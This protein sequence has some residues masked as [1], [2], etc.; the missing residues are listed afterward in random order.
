MPSDSQPPRRIHAGDR[1]AVALLYREYFPV[2]WRYVYAK[3]R[4]D[5]QATEDVV[6]ETFLGAVEWARNGTGDIE[7]PARWLTAVAKRQVAYYLRKK[8]RGN[9]RHA[10]DVPDC[11]VDPAVEASDEET[12]W[13]L[14][15]VLDS[16]PEEERLA[17]EW[18]YLDGWSA[19]DIAQ[20][21]GRSVRAAESVLYRARR[22]FRKL[23]SAEDPCDR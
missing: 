3:L 13:R 20:G 10:D 19:A 7:Q 16:L 14:A 22:S 4:G 17:L 23:W 1:D 5:R 6:S 12:R 21:L 15:D 2:V 11:G 18:K 8:Q 9:V